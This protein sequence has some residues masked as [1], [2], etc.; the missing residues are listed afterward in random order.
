MGLDALAHRLHDL[1]VDAD[2]VVAAHA[3]LARHAGGH[4]HHVGPGDRRIVAGAR[5]LRVEAFDR[6]GLGDVQRLALGNAVDD[7]E[8]HDVAQFLEAGEKGQGSADLAGTDEGDLAA[9]HVG[10]ASFETVRS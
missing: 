1:E 4:D 6:R 3:G 9:C 5:E 2:Q 7:V 10:S 8:Q